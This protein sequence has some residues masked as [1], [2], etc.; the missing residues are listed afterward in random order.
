MI[1][2]LPIY[3]LLVAFLFSLPGCT[4]M[5]KTEQGALSGAVI[6]AG[7]GAGIS[8][9]S[10]GNAGVGALVGGAIGGIAGG[11][12]GHQQERDYYY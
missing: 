7:A 2:R 5:T 9:I 4:N 8:A 11:L 1:S 6:G 12:Y 3:I 10:G